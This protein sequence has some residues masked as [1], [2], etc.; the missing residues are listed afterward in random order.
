MA[1]CSPRPI[2]DECAKPRRIVGSWPQTPASS[3]SLLD[4]TKGDRTLRTS[5]YSYPALKY[6]VKKGQPKR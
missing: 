4:K 5:S 6:G 3:N 2:Y 1:K